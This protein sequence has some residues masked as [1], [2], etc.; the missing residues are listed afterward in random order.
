MENDDGEDDMLADPPVLNDT[1]SKKKDRG[2]CKV[3]ETDKTRKRK[4]N[5]ES[6]SRNKRREARVHGKPYIST[7]KQFVVS[8]R[9][10]K[11]ACT[12]RLK[13]NEKIFENRRLK[14]FQELY[15]LDANS[16]NQFISQ[17]KLCGETSGKT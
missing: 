7:K 8:G 12:C 10:L 11:P 13:C 2:R 6:W 16:Q 14:I 5:Q 3:E 1:S 17:R 9:C 15:L 4:R